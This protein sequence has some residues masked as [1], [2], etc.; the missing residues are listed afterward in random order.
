MS[1][2]W[3]IFK[4]GALLYDSQAFGPSVPPTVEPPVVPP[5]VTPPVTNPG[6][7][8]LGNP[9]ITHQPFATGIYAMPV[10]VRRGTIQLSNENISP[11][12]I[13]E[14][15]ITASP[16]DFS[17]ATMAIASGGSTW[18]DLYNPRNPGIVIPYGAQYY[19]N[20]RRISGDN[21][22]LQMSWSSNG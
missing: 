6:Y 13:Y 7:P 11:G 4:N 10:G 8:T 14:W 1:D 9:G 21:N 22:G 20:I 15:S 3:Q 19:L 16:G 12:M 17:N 5:V 2:R 18:S